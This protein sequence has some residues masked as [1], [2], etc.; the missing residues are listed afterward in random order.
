M[1]NL[2]KKIL[3]VDDDSSILAGI[4]RTLCR[5]FEISTAIGAD[6][7]FE[8]INEHG[9]FAVI[10]SDMKMTGMN[11]IEFLTHIKQIYPQTICIMLTGYADIDAAI[12]AVN[13]GL[14]FRFLTKP[15]P[16]DI[17]S[18]TLD[19]AIHN[20]RHNAG[21]KSYT[22]TVNIIDGKPDYN[23]TKRT[24]GVLAVTGYN[25][26]ELENNPSIRMDMVLKD[27]QKMHSEHF[28][29]ILNGVQSAPIEFEIL[30]KDGKRVWLRD[31]VIARK[32]DKGNI[33]AIDGLVEDI[34][35]I[36]QVSKLL[37]QSQTRYERMVSNMP[38]VVFQC[39]ADKDYNIKVLFASEASKRILNIDPNDV[40]ADPKV[41][42][43]TLS[44]EQYQS[45]MGR[46]IQ[47]IE[48]NI[49]FNWQGWI[50]IDGQE[51]WI[52]ITAK[53]ERQNDSLTV[54]DGLLLDI[55]ESVIMENNLKRANQQLLEHNQLKTEFVTVV[56]HELRTPLFIFKNIISNALSGVYGW[57][58]K[59]LRN[60]LTVANGTI[61]RLSRIVNDFLDC[62]Q[63]EN[64]T[65]KL[66]I[67]D[68]DITEILN[69]SVGNFLPVLADRKLKIQCMLPNKPI[70][71]QIDKD[72]IVQAI[73]NL[74]ANAIK[75]SNEGGKI[76]VFLEENADEVQISIQDYGVGIS[77]EDIEKIFSRFVQVHKIYRNGYGG[78]G[79]GLSIS[80]D[81][82]E[83]HNGRIW[84]QSQP[85]KGSCFNIALPKIFKN[86]RLKN[87]TEQPCEPENAAI[88]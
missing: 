24:G 3:F 6:D 86:P 43:D 27:Y 58:G 8:V 73:T 83:M 67:D 32:D 28:D 79:L 70:I 4:R 87:K 9:S 34:T 13:K 69:Q 2:N 42:F 11:G 48:K 14:L 84:V 26:R 68:Y 12:E 35:A 80:K 38:G 64:G 22:Y 52:K 23:N 57:V 10:V 62:S 29:N 54:W 18:Q 63:I 71:I 75:F 88:L 66:N 74:L 41:F 5:K 47:S 19:D 59:K 7:A 60:N 85:A 49:D 46:I 15:C 20:Y 39:T 81:F 45:F 77:Q 37:H 1:P 53:M 78:T 55:T 72:R 76:D 51:K 33:T 30:S 44:Q 56:S 31:T 61:D 40:I 65:L 25:P 17:L 21:Q 50:T 36:K 16:T 82:V